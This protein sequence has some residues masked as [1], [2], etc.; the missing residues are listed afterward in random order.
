MQRKKEFEKVKEVIKENFCFGECGIY[1][2]RNL[3]GDYMTN[4]FDGEYFTVDLCY[5]YSYFEV[6]GTNANEFN[7]LLKFYGNLRPQKIEDE[8][9]EEL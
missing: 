5:R 6:F 1:N 2:S 7:K 8:E 9:N 4:I 3:V